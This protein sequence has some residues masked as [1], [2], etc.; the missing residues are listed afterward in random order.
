MNKK[1]MMISLLVILMITVCGASYYYKKN[2]AEA[3]TV[4]SSEEVTA[5][6]NQKIMRGEISEIKGNDIKFTLTEEKTTEKTMEMIIP[7][8]TDVVTKLG[9]TT[10]FARLAAGDVV[11]LLME[12]DGTEDVI[13]KMWIVG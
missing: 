1:K 9:T 6:E 3:T 11:Q 4:E 7:V 10:T 5:G 12:N 2:Q 8:G 13:L